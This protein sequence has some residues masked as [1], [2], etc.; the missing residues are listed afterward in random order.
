M[1]PAER[2]QMIYLWP[3]VKIQEVRSETSSTVTVK[4]LLL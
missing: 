2:I 4:L 1:K 3:G